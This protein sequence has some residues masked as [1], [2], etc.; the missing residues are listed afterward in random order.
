[1]RARP[2]RVLPDTIELV[3]SR[4]RDEAFTLQRVEAD[5]DSPQSGGLR[6]SI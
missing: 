3:E 4:E 5:R 1:M 2:R 6:P